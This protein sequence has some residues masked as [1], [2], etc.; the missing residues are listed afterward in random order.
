MV[1]LLSRFS[2]FVRSN[3]IPAKAG[4]Q[5]FVAGMQVVAAKARWI[6]ARAALGRNDGEWGSLHTAA[7]FRRK[8]E[9]SPGFPLSHQCGYERHRDPF[10]LR[11]ILARL[12]GFLLQIAGTP[13]KLIKLPGSA[14]TRTASLEGDRNGRPEVR[15]RQ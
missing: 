2:I 7:S 3:V 4:I 1:E 10:G 14:R 6:P 13:V 15:C 12:S 5:T 9:S 8:P 11:R